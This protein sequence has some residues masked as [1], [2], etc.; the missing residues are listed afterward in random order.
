M[1]ISTSSSSAA[2][3]T[4]VV[5]TAPPKGA[6]VHAPPRPCPSPC[7]CPSPFPPGRRS[8]S[9]CRLFGWSSPPSGAQA[10]GGARFRARSR[11]VASPERSGLAWSSSSMREWSVGCHATPETTPS[12]AYAAS[13]A[14]S[15]ALVAPALPPAPPAAPGTV[16]LG[17]VAPARP[18]ERARCAGAGV[19]WLGVPAD[20]MATP[21][22]DPE[23][24]RV[25]VGSPSANL[26]IAWS[27]SHRW[28]LELP[29]TTVESSPERVGHQ[30][31]CRTPPLPVVEMTNSGA[32]SRTARTSHPLTTPPASSECVTTR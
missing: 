23:A 20:G 9:S 30:P 25:P 21:A 17:G 28:T 31:T 24:G 32:L 3:A 26:A 27:T 1:R 13:H 19:A 2:C 15:C 8:C 12:H 6:R 14:V 11:S 5:C 18:A 10:R 16:P 4:A 29:S 22:G 7:P